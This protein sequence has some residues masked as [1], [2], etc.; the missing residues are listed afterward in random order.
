MSKEITH[1]GS[2]HCR[3]VQ[4]E[5]IAP[6]EITVLECNCS[7]CSMIDFIHLIIAKDNFKLIMG[8]DNLT[9]YEFNTKTAKHFFCKTCGIKS[10]YIPRSHPNCYS[11]NVRCLDTK[12]FNSITKNQ[13]DGM[14]WENN[15]HQL[16]T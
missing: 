13:F 16:T 1:K 11:V 15:I 4:F 10:F 2:C 8:K 9:T 5:I 14:N 3:A 7:I 6:K 12:T